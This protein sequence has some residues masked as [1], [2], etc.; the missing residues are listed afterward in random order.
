MVSVGPAYRRLRPA[1]RATRPAG[2]LCASVARWGAPDPRPGRLTG[3]TGRLAARSGR[4]A[5]CERRSRRGGGKGVAWLGAGRVLGCGMSSDSSIGLRRIRAK[6]SLN[7]PV[8]FFLFLFW[9]NF[10]CPQ[11]ILNERIFQKI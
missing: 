6:M 11:S 10:T 3:A 2:R 8:H 7:G 4:L 5:G 9:F 1:S